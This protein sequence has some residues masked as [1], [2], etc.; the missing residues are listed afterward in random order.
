MANFPFNRTVINTRERPLSSDIN[1]AQSEIDRTLRDALMN[2]YLPRHSTY[3]DYASYPVSGM[4][5]AGM[6]VR[7]KS[8]ASMIVTVDIGLGMSYSG[9]V[10]SNIGGVPEVNDLSLW[11]PLYLDAPKDI[12]LDAAPGSSY[13][14]DIIE[15]RTNRLLTDPSSRDVLNTSSGAFEAQVVNKALDW[16][17]DG[18]FSRVLAGNPSTGA[19]GYKVGATGAAAPDPTNNYMKIATIYIPTG[20]TAVDADKINDTRRMLSPAG[21]ACLSTTVFIPAGSTTPNMTMLRCPPGIV[22][23]A[24]CISFNPVEL[25]IYVLAGAA[26]LGAPVPVANSCVFPSTITPTYAGAAMMTVDS[27]IQAKLAGASASPQVKAAI[28]QKG[29]LIQILTSGD[30]TANNAQVHAMVNLSL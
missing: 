6:K 18:S 28:G 5:G 20:T 23:S 27:V 3:P 8:P 26:G 12:V 17:L 30:A 4:I 14:Y 24:V 9:A 29:Y 25:E 10:D 11:K 13:R 2:I 15:V 1:R 16:R 7:P 22:V 21:L 19:I